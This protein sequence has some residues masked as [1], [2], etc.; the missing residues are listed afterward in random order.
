MEIAS[1]S[2]SLNWFDIIIYKIISKTSE[3]RASLELYDID[4]M[5]NINEAIELE[6]YLESLQYKNADIK[7]AQAKKEAEMKRLLG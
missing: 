7:T 1:K 4:Y 2:L 5:L 3:T 6:S